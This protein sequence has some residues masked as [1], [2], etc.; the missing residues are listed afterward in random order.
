MERG[1]C[2]ELLEHPYFEAMRSTTEY[3]RQADDEVQR[4]R[5]REQRKRE[6]DKMP[7]SRAVSSYCIILNIKGKGKVRLYS[8]AYAVS[9]VLS[10]QACSHGLWPVAI[11]PYVALI[12]RL[13]QFKNN[14]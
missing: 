7:P 6:Q 9:V 10:S 2:S 13:I 5:E 11:Q 3:S 12:C 4:R 1:T 8:A 14:L